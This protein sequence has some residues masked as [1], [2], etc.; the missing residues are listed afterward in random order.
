M[1]RH[2]AEYVR[3]ACSRRVDSYANYSSRICNLVIELYSISSRTAEICLMAESNER[4][5]EDA[6]KYVEDDTSEEG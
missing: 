6:E 3:G 2:F 5:K 4:E 1:F